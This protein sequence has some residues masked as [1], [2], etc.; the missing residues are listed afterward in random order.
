MPLAM[1]MI[2]RKIFSQTSNSSSSGSRQAKTQ[3]FANP[4]T[5][6]PFIL[7][8]F[9]SFLPMCLVHHIMTLKYPRWGKYGAPPN[10]LRIQLWLPNKRL[11]SRNWERTDWSKLIV[12]FHLIRFSSPFCGTKKTWLQTTGNNLSLRCAGRTTPWQ[13]LLCQRP[14]TSYRPRLCQSDQGILDGCKC[15]VVNV[16]LL[17]LL[18][19]F[20][21]PF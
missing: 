13:S 16:I 8:S 10:P 21:V 2:C 7:S 5:P 4:V 19:F 12:N 15:C 11:S 20:L 17:S 6:P 3:L 14:Q 1:M 18:V 9:F